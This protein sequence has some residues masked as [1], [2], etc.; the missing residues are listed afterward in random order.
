M[1]RHMVVMP[2]LVRLDVLENYIEFLTFN[3]CYYPGALILVLNKPPVKRKILEKEL[4]SFINEREVFKFALE[5]EDT[6]INALKCFY[7]NDL[8]SW[9]SSVDCI[10]LELNNEQFKISGC[11]SNHFIGVTC[12][13]PPPESM[14][15]K[16]DLTEPNSMNSLLNSLEAFD[17]IH[18][19]PPWNYLSHSPVR[20]F[21]ISYSTL[22]KIYWSFAL[23]S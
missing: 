16:M 19:D 9:S 6:I 3:D 23:E 13:C 20:S 22:S 14:Q 12:S 10:S 5:Y 11:G 18:I 1:E 17:L 8:L 15:I 4:V 2:L 7:T 21:N